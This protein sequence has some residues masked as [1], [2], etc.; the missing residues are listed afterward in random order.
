MNGRGRKGAQDVASQWNTVEGTHLS[1][2]PETQITGD[3]SD[4]RILD[5]TQT[6]V[7]DATFLFPRT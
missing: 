6:P 3:V 1:G 2:A 5:C 7:A 4:P